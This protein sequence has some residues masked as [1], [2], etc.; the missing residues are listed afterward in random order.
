MVQDRCVGPV[1]ALRRLLAAVGAGTQ[2][3]MCVLAPFV[4]VSCGGDP[5]ARAEYDGEYPAN[6]RAYVQASVDGY[7]RGEY[8]ADDTFVGLERNCGEAGQLWAR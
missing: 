6:C 8:S 5:N 1:S 4:L 2:V 3:V 7:R